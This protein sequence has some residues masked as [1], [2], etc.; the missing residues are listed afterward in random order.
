MQPGVRLRLAGTFVD[1]FAD[2]PV[3]FERLLSRLRDVAVAARDS[4]GLETAIELVRLANTMELERYDR[5]YNVRAS[6]EAAAVLAPSPA[7]VT[8]QHRMHE[9]SEALPDLH[10]EAL[11]GL[12][13][14]IISEI[15]E[16]GLVSS[17][18]VNRVA[19]A[20]DQIAEGVRPRD[21]EA[22]AVLSAE[23]ARIAVA[24]AENEP[25]E[26]TH[27]KLVYDADSEGIGR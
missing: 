16:D 15:A 1:L 8:V 19:R 3:A 22:R 10:A 6:M 13:G 5:A 18:L 7:L 9:S 26:P 20:Q 21:S 27:L 17:E 11:E 25:V 4:E 12:V 14:R 24:L 23:L 2:D